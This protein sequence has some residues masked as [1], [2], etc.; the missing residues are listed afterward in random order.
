MG[1]CRIEKDHWL[2][3]TPVAHRGLHSP[4]SGVPENSMKA[5]AAAIENGYPIEMDIQLTKD[6]VLVCFHDD[7]LSRMTGVDAFV[8][9]KTF[10]EVRAMRL[11]GT[12]EIIPTFDEFLAFVG[13]RTPIVIEL[14]S[15]KNRGI[16]ADETIKRLDNYKG[17]FVVQSFD[18]F[19]VREFRKKRP[20]FIRG[21]L[22]DKDRHEGLSWIT[23]KLLGMA[24]FNFTV[25]PDF[26]NMNVKYLPV[27]GK[28]IKNRR[29]I[30]WTARSEEDRKKAEKYA[31]N[32]IFEGIR[33]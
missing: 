20:Q 30:C 3:K 7:T 6:N 17:D 33:P 12:N 25:K 1:K 4:E 31:D 9:D 29:L 18:P 27:K 19:I 28:M 14:K 8:R 2:L 10:E 23:D 15:Q 16:I 24:F 5:Y 21:Q 32:Y 11:A 26:I 13:G 22:V